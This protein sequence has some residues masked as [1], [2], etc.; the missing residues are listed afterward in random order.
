MNPHNPL[1]IAEL[2]ATKAR[3]A[4]TLDNLSFFKQASYDIKQFNTVE[5]IFKN[6]LNKLNISVKRAII[7]V[8]APVA[9]D[10]VAFVNL[11]LNFS[12]SKLK[13]NIF[14]DSLLVLN[15]LELQAYGIESLDKEK[16]F[17]IGDQ[18]K[19]LS[20]SKVLVSPGTGL[21]LA[22]IVDGIVVPS[23]AGH[24]NI[25]KNLP[26]FSSLVEKF[27]T[28]NKRMST[29]EDFLS[30][31]G[32]NYIYRYLSKSKF[33]PYSNEDI[34]SKTEDPDCNE[35]KYLMLYLLAVYLRYMALFWGATGGVYLSGSIVNSLLLDTNF[36]Q[37]RDDFEDSSKMN[38][39]LKEIPIFLIKELNLG[40]KGALKLASSS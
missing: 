24:L 33:K 36:K 5:A 9:G 31:K 11:D 35:T 7:G 19:S 30:G 22:A 34:L 23:E 2:G 10:E 26:K 14:Q 15:D 3:L 12:Q 18:K 1:L 21:G 25:P 32:I 28:E 27:Q 13:E 40:F 37:F 29:F 6:Y 16:I 39:L 4:I 20:Q 17:I 38:S 8:A